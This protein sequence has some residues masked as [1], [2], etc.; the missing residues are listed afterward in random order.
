MFVS[1]GLLIAG[2]LLTFVTNMFFWRINRKKDGEMS[3]LQEREEKSGLR[4]QH[5]LDKNDPE[6]RHEIHRR[7]LDIALHRESSIYF[8]YSL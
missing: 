3:Q 7:L 2:T 5:K 1:A 8:R 6:H 4:Y